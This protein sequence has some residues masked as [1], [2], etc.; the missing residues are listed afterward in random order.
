[1]PKP[2]GENLTQMLVGMEVGVKSQVH[3]RMDKEIIDELDRLVRDLRMG[4]IEHTRN[5]M[6]S[7]LLQKYLKEAR[8][9]FTKLIE[10]N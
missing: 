6:I 3:I 4:G 7:W 8:E 10:E 1:M 5:S 2:K 9:Y